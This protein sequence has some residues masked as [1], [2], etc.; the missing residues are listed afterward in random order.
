M[1]MESVTKI[2]WNNLREAIPSF[3]SIVIMPFTYTI[4]YGILGGLITHFLIVGINWIL[5]CI[6]SWC[7]LCQKWGIC[8]PPHEHIR[9]QKESDG[10][11]REK[12]ELNPMQSGD[13][14][15]TQNIVMESTPD[16]DV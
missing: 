4:A 8:T 10:D 13:A 11:S 9:E 3:V 12:V 5:D 14:M 15:R 2:Q 16:H 6:H 7:P 1:G